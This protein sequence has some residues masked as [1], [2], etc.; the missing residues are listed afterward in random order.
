MVGDRRMTKKFKDTSK[1]VSWTSI[2]HE[3]LNWIDARD[4]IENVL[5][6]VEALNEDG[7]RSKA[8]YT[9]A[10]INAA[11]KRILKG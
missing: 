2:H 5:R 6:R 9:R 10:E 7:T 4:V 11:W 1:A 3:P 8:D